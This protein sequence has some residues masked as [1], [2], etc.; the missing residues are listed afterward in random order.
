[1]LEQFMKNSKKKNNAKKLSS[2]NVTPNTGLTI[3]PKKNKSGVVKM[4]PM[5]NSF[6]SDSS[7]SF[8]KHS[9]LNDDL[10]PHSKKR[11]TIS[12]S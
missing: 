4:I 6:S 10:S 5:E 8:E 9:S 12:I 1:M 11:P 7:I 2:V 3:T